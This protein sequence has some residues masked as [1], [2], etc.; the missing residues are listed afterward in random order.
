MVYNPPISPEKIIEVVERADSDLVDQLTLEIIKYHPNTYTFTKA[1]T[2]YLVLE[3]CKD[4]PCV[5]VRPSIVGSS[6]R[7][8]FPGWIDNFNGPTAVFVA[9]GQGISRSFL[10]NS[11]YTADLIPVDVIVNFLIASAWYTAT[12]KPTDIKV[13]NYTTGQIKPLT[14]GMIERYSLESLLKNPLENMVLVPGAHFTSSK[15]VKFM[16]HIFEESVPSH[17]MDFYLKVM[18]KKTL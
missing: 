8:P 1:I 15:S 11:N 18:N 5:I 16:R 2:E 7:E 17:I 13:Y 10:G 4:I 9:I 14:W 12:R 3:E 6:W